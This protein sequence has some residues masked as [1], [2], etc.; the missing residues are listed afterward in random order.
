MGYRN[1]F[2]HPKPD[3][4]ARYEA[5]H[6]RLLRTDETGAIALFVENNSLTV[7]SARARFPHYW[8]EALSPQP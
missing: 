4:V 8:E 7:T 5:R 6:I 2:G 1:H 3:V